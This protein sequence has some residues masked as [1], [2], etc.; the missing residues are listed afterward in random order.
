VLFVP[1]LLGIILAVVKRETRGYGG[2]LRL[3]RS[4]LLESIATALLA[5]IRMVFYC[6]FVLLNLIGRAV[7]W[8]G[9]AEDLEET[10]WGQA[11][12]WHGLDTL[13]AIVWVGGIRWLHPEA[14][15]WLVPVAGALLLAVPL[16]VLASRKTL[17]ARARA[18]GWFVTPEE[19]DPPREIRELEA[20]LEAAA[21]R[22]EARRSGFV[23]AVVD[24]LLNA[25][26][27][28][29][30]RGPRHLAPHLRDQRLRLVKRALE[31]GPAA[32][33]DS[34]QRA[35]LYDAASMHELHA[36]VWRLEDAEAAARWSL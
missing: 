17:G 31:D 28:G 20:D 21:G 12:R 33:S 19:T 13:V 34:E 27:A 4:V 35:V 29:L 3:L 25:I 36:R 16:S 1:K 9:G 11:W 18:A 10:T 2:F 6:R 22:P 32:L 30:L 24:P 15:W 26:H 23:S 8:R 14:F 7:S 5:P